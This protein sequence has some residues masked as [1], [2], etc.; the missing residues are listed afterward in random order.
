M[1]TVFPFKIQEVFQMKKII[2]VILSV[3]IIFSLTACK[4]KNEINS[5]LESE[6]NSSVLTTSNDEALSPDESEVSSVTENSQELPTDSKDTSPS[7]ATPN[8]TQSSKPSPNTSSGNTSKPTKPKIANIDFDKSRAPSTDV[9]SAFDGDY[10][11]YQS[12]EHITSCSTSLCRNKLDGSSQEVVLPDNSPKFFKAINGKLY[13]LR[14]GY[15]YKCNG[16]GSNLERI[17]IIDKISYFEIAGDWIFAIRVINEESK[18]TRVAELYMIKID[19]SDLRRLQPNV[20]DYNSLDLTLYGFNRGYLYYEYECFYI[21]APFTYQ[22]K[23][24]KY[25][26]D[27]RSSDPQPEELDIHLEF[28]IGNEKVYTPSL[29]TNY[30]S[31]DT[32]EY[33]HYYTSS[34]IPCGFYCLSLENKKG[35]LLLDESYKYNLHIKL[36]DYYVFDI[37]DNHKDGNHIMF[38]DLN[39][40]KK[41]FVTPLP[42]GHSNDFF[43]GIADYDPN[44]NYI[45]AIFFDYKLNHGILYLIGPDGIVSELYNKKIK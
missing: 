20:T 11:Y 36:K 34:Y 19:C 30:I 40:N 22:T 7:P 10:V 25:R 2:S 21:I 8:I 4:T 13:F 27:Y 28:S 14:D 39:G 31:Y 15:I 3:V 35:V 24:F 42:E 6:H 38:V 9:A 1:R 18:Y 26:I 12:A 29:D 44:S 45:T 32:I 23:T 17:T 37:N 16:D 33:S 41:E 5:S 43:C